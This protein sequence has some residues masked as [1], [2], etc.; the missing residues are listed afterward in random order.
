MGLG[1]VP[2]APEDRPMGSLSGVPIGRM[3]IDVMTYRVASI[4]SDPPL[5]STIGDTNLA[6]AGDRSIACNRHGSHPG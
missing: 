2:D 5:I 1:E 6:I 4:G 3:L